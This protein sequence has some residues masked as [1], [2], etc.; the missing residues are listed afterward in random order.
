[1][2]AQDTRTQLLT[3]NPWRLMVSLSLPAIIGM[4]VIG[5]YNFMDAVYVGN[6]IGSAAMTAVKVSYPFTLINSGISTLIGVGSAS[7]LSRAV[8][9]NDRDTVDRIMGNLSVCIIALSLAVTVL[10]MIFTSQLLTLAGAKGDI[11]EL[12]VRYLRIIFI[13]SL[14]VN[15]AQSANM[16]MRGEGLLKKAMLIMGLGA[17]LNIILDPLFLWLLKSVEG[18]AYATILSQFTQACVTLWYFTKK[19]KNVR[20][21]RLKLDRELLPEVLGVGVSAMLM[22]VMQLVQQTVMYSA[23]QKYGGSEWQTVLSAALSLQ[24]FAFIPLWGMS[25]GFQPAAGTNYGAKDYSRVKTLMRV[26]VTGATALS[27]IFYLPVMLAPKAMLSMLIADN[28]ALVNAGVSNLRIFFSSYITLGLMIMTITLFQSLGQGGK[29]A[30]L[31]I[32]RQIAFFIPLIFLLPKLY[33]AKAAI[34]GV[35][36]APVITDLLVLILS[37]CLIISTFRKIGTSTQNRKMQAIRRN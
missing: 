31:T 9:K 20:I 29:A 19:S 27:L 30:L 23:A 1:M 25:Q 28:P 2:S 26:F 5:L 21:N 14:F 16:V 18:A 37:L 24:A 4:V 32:L 34:N 35:F 12:G 6:M 8:G 17:A 10:G 36:F 13:G 11:M 33:P 22:Q 3:E 7:V 15:F